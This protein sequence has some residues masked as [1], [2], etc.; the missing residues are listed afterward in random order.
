MENGH[1]PPADI[2]Q[3]PFEP[4]AALAGMGVEL[5][6]FAD[7]RAMDHVGRRRRP[8]RPS[9]HVLALI[10]S[11]VGGHRRDF[12]DEPLSER[13]VAYL[14]PGVVHEWSRVENI[15]GMLVLFT[16]SAIDLETAAVADTSFTVKLDHGQ[17]ELATTA[18]H[19]LRMELRNASRE[20]DPNALAIARHVLASLV[21]R[22]SAAAPQR[23]SG[24]EHRLFRSYRAEVED[25]FT[26]WHTVETYAAA[27]NYSTRSISRATLAATG[28]S[29]K[30]FLDER[31][32]LEAKRLLVDTDMTIQQC[33]TALGFTQPN[34]F[35]AFFTRQVGQ[36]PGLWRKQEGQSV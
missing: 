20:P 21:R 1:R 16:P 27:I 15:D 8:Q 32:T 34:N 28:V 6:T 24:D 4:P 7:L 10:E 18:A 11:G 33:A 3:V 29:A 31:I 19:H 22:A 9:F 17:W 13:S 36:P 2:W 26:Q 14:Q 12:L 23:T 35:S 30:R 5:L 25:N